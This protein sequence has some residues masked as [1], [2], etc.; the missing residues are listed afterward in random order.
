M[1]ANDSFFQRKK[2]AAVLKHAVLAEYFNVFC[3]MVGGSFSGPVWLVDGYAGP[4]T[5]DA[6][7][8]GETVTGSPIVA[9]EIA[10]KA[11]QWKSPRNIRCAFIEQKP[12]YLKKLRSNVKPFQERGCHALVLGGEVQEQLPK[13]WEEVGTSPV[14]TLLDP[15]GVSMARGMMTGTLLGR[16][17]PPSEVLLNINVEAVSRHGGYL[18][19]GAGGTPEIKPGLSSQGVEKADLFFGGKW[20]RARFLD[21]RDETSSAALAA[22]A[23]VDE[24]RAAIAKETGTLSI[25]VPIRRRANRAPLF[26]LTLFYRHDAAGYKFADAAARASRKWRDAYRR[27]DLDDFFE[28]HDEQEMLPIMG[29]IIRE[30]S[31]SRSAAAERDL[32]SDCISA[33]ATNIQVLVVQSTQV[34]VGRNVVPILG[35]TLSLAGE[36][37]IRKAWDRLADA[38]S[39]DPRDKKKE[40]WKQFIV[41]R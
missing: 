27:Q 22:A 36:S 3:A 31:A 24:Y 38:G 20:W 28:K 23:V 39:V 34:A 15:F 29:D 2:P 16:S 10:E 13:A 7:D 32:E 41:K 1:A 35:D 18:Q 12:N 6:D 4:G 8:D 17:K 40:L 25:S 37:T 9:L 21:A 30:D 5:Y 14:L 19:R 33:V 26:L 11:A